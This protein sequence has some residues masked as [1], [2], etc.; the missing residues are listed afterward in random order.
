MPDKFYLIM[1][2]TNE[3]C[4]TCI[5][6]LKSGR[7]RIINIIPPSVRLNVGVGRNLLRHILSLSTISVVFLHE[8]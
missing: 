8:A 1:L 3:E 7:D 6:S 2:P 5:Q 4:I